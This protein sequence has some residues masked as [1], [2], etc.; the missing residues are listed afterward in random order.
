MSEVKWEDD[1][2]GALNDGVIILIIR[3]VWW[4][5][6]S[7]FIIS[8]T[9]KFKTGVVYYWIIHILKFPM[10]WFESC[11]CILYVEGFLSET[12]SQSDSMLK[13][14]TDTTQQPIAFD[15]MPH[16]HHRI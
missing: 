5:S 6:I 16:H 8:K 11:G 10:K 3:V 7:L 9:K 12:V 2:D 15:I 14:L 13:C 1:Y 4:C